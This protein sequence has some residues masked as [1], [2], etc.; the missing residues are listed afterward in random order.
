MG[1]RGGGGQNA[2][3]HILVFKYPSRDRVKVTDL[4]VKYFLFKAYMPA[5]KYL[6]KKAKKLCLIGEIVIESHSFLEY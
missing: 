2:P 3:Q 1:F 4:Y 5:K 6:R